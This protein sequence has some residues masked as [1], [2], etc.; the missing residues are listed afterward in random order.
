MIQF[1]SI[2]IHDIEDIMITLETKEQAKANLNVVVTC[3]INQGW[4]INP[5]KI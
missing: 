4:L 2:V 1:S 3:M 5:A